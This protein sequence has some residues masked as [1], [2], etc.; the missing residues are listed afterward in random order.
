MTV[1]QKI[2]AAAVVALLVVS[3]LTITNSIITPTCATDAAAAIYATTPGGTFTG[4]GC[5]FSVPSGIEITKPITINGGTYVESNVARPVP[6]IFQVSLTHNV[7]LENLNIIGSEPL[8]GG[9]HPTLVTQEGMDILA[10][11]HVSILNVTTTNT[12]GD[13]LTIFGIPGHGGTTNLTV[14]GLTVTN[15]GRQ[16]ITP[17]ALK[18]ATFNNTHVRSSA[19]S[20]WDWESDIPGVGAGYVTVSNSS[21]AKNQNMIEHLDGPISFVNCTMGKAG[22]NV[23]ND[24]TFPVTFTGGLLP[25]GPAFSGTPGAGIRQQGGT[26]TF[27]HVSITRTIPKGA[28]VLGPTYKVTSG[29]LNFI[30]SPV[31]VVPGITNI[32]GPFS[33]VNVT[34]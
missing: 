12:Y 4:T 14:D 5:T 10:S 32:V 1:R 21:W 3:G 8:T 18:H 16:G 19:D 11:D 20:S 30:A 31:P 17:A 13:G 6:P 33:I 15:A 22:M 28:L 23:Q 27:D 34:P 26:L 24:G 25:L 7:T 9:Y 29:T 2:T